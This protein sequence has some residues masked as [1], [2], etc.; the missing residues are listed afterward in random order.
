MPKLPDATA[1]GSAAVPKSRRTVLDYRPGVEAESYERAVRGIGQAQDALFK[2]QQL[3]QDQFRELGSTIDE[4]TK[5][6]R[7]HQ[8]K[9]D[10]A[11]AKANFVKA[12]LA[13]R[14]ELE[15]DPD[16][17]TYLPRYTAAMEKQRQAIRS[18]FSDR[19]VGLLFDQEM[20]LDI[21][22][23]R[24]DL[25][26]KAFTKEK[27]SKIAWANQSLDDLEKDYLG[28]GDPASRAR[29][30]GSMNAIY[31]AMT[32]YIGK[33]EAQSQRQKRAGNLFFQ[34]WEVI[35][36]QDPQ[37]VITRFAP[38]APA[39][40]TQAA[41]TGGFEAAMPTVF[42]NEGGHTPLD[43][44]SGAPAIYGINAKWH[45]AAYDEAKRIT[46]EQGEAAGKAY[47]QENFYRREFWDRHGLDDVPP[48]AQTIVFD[49]AVNH[50]AGFT[51]RLV[52]EAKAGATPAELIA[53]RRAE[54]QRLHQTSPEKYPASQ[55]EQWNRRLD[56]VSSG[57][58]AAGTLP[59]IPRRGDSGDFLSVQQRLA[60]VR[61]ARETQTRQRAAF[62]VQFDERLKDA[63]AMAL[64]GVA[65]P[66][67]P[68]PDEFV[69]RYGEEWQ[70]KWSQYQANVRHGQS[71]KTVALMSPIAQEQAL[72][73]IA[74]QP[75]PGFATQQKLYEDLGKSIT[76]ANTERQE[77]PI[78]FAQK[79]GLA[80]AEPLDFANPKAMAQQL[81]QRASIASTM[82]G[83]LGTRPALFTKA[84]AAGLGPMFDGMT[85]GQQFAFI[86][87]LRNSVSD[88]AA[89]RGG[90]AQLSQSAP[91]AAVAGNFL[92]RPLLGET[93]PN[94]VAKTILKGARA[95]NPPAVVGPD[96]RESRAKPQ[97]TIP[98]DSK[99]RAY[100]VEEAGN[101]FA[102]LPELQDMAYQSFRALYAG[103]MI[104]AGKFDGKE[105]PKIAQQAARDI[106]GTT[107]EQNGQTVVAPWGVPPHA[108]AD[109]LKASYT[110]AI[111]SLGL[112]PERFQFRD[113]RFVNT[114]GDGT[115][116]VQNFMDGEWVNMI[117]TNARPLVVTANPMGPHQ[118]PPGVIERAL[119]GG[120]A[121]TRGGIGV[122]R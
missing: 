105:D 93:N 52:A 99:L 117:G 80:P 11:T 8:A 27:E 115:Y 21:A 43:G 119:V 122:T 108:F 82:A 95:L 81:R 41:P 110:A 49:G 94:E 33:D 79:H 4:I 51:E 48:E 61:L 16:Y 114:G 13:I 32:P 62:N 72:R 91:I 23:G 45:K 10:L 1:L 14:S 29:I 28:T 67:A 15:R 22:R 42:A 106:I 64:A 75:G 40:S 69:S 24:A 60:L 88:P 71:V 73:Q 118:R 101:A 90:L 7:E 19:E 66:A 36:Q 17:A 102:N 107:W 3:V 34:E 112:D 53:M 74:P 78:G 96:G 44:S 59:S 35:A 38:V 47:A 6:R 70:T 39:S 120:T 121:V 56:T 84:E 20:D 65:N 86:S 103:R 89:Y 109:G 25:T 54:Y 100:F 37:A 46:D 2:S 26:S 111:R 85:D 98:D 18:S 83:E 92:G 12:D 68:T 55:L 50:W 9:I 116:F 104:D 113:M 30:A 87:G 77:D 57:Q 5:E 63:D 31:D 76:A 97:I 58:P